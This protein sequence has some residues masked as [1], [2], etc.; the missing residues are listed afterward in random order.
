MAKNIQ[1]LWSAP[2]FKRPMAAK[3]NQKIQKQICNLLYIICYKVMKIVSQL[4]FSLQQGPEPTYNL[5]KLKEFLRSCFA[6]RR[7][8]RGGKVM[9][10]TSVHRAKLN[11]VWTET[12]CRGCVC[13]KHR[14][15]NLIT[16]WVGFSEFF[17]MKSPS[18]IITQQQ[19]SILKI[20]NDLSLASGASFRLLSIP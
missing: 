12:W 14:Q 13:R 3:L 7:R 15:P 6:A 2:T 8:G 11:S 1:T 9:S 18:I 5:T 17:P 19:V 20:T 4:S 10:R 16:S